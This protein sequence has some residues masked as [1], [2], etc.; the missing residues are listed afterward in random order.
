MSTSSSPIARRG[1][2]LEG[3]LESRLIARMLQL[4]KLKLVGNSQDNP[5]FS[6]LQYLGCCD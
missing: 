4:L 2:L 5:V 3:S 6:Y 1:Q